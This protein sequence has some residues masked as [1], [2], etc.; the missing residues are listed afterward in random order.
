MRRMKGGCRSCDVRDGYGLGY[1]VEMGLRV[2]HFS[3]CMCISDIERNMSGR[4]M[5]L[6]K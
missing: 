3:F 4:F 2:Y 5:G 6:V 1:G